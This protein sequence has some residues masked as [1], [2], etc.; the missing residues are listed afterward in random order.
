VGVVSRRHS[1]SVESTSNVVRF[2][3]FLQHFDFV[4]IY[5]DCFRSTNGKLEM[6]TQSTNEVTISFFFYFANR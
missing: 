1:S 6:S 5:V 3:F 2:F 4:L